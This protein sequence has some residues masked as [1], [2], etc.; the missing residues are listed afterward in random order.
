MSKSTIGR[1]WQAFGLKPHRADTFKLSN[2]PFFVEKVQDVVGLY[3]NPPD[4]GR[5][6]RRREE[7]G[8]GVGPLATGVADDARHAREADA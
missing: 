4:R 8:P 7:P 3:L 5:A 2:D 1:I 6:L